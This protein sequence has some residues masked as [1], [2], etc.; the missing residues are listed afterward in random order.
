VG[1]VAGDHLEPGGSAPFL[2]VLVEFDDGH[3]VTL[4]G[5]DARSPR[6]HTSTTYDNE[7]HES[8]YIVRR[9]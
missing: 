9:Q 8:R 7:S 3:V 4:L 1:A 2:A 5:E 6:A